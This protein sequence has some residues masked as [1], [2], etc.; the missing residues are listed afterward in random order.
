[1]VFFV[2]TPF[3][4]ARGYRGSWRPCCPRLWVQDYTPTMKM[5][6]TITFK[7]IAATYNYI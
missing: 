2:M 3:G 6:V 7:I 4:S 5:D 1:V